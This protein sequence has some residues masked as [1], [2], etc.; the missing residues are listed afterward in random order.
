M[1]RI[2]SRPSCPALSASSSSC[3]AACARSGCCA[4]RPARHPSLSRRLGPQAFGPSEKVWRSHVDPGF[5]N[6]WLIDRGV[7][8][9]SGDSDHF[10]REH[11]PDK[12]GLINP[13]ST[14]CH[15][16]RTNDSEASTFPPPDP[17]AISPAPNVQLMLA[18]AAKHKEH[19]IRL[20]TIARLVSNQS[21]TTPF[22]NGIH[23]SCFLPIY[24]CSSPV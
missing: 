9:V 6:P 7:S 13:G 16:F 24:S 12:D 21:V 10:W 14:V 15:R 17:N 2:G 8:P 18:P 19:D 3:A 11:P 23:V 5:I 1:V 22:K 20:Q 4:F